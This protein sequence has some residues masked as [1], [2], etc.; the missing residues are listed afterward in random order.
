M[1]TQSFTVI[2]QNKPLP[3]GVSLGAWCPSMDLL[4]LVF[5]DGTL[6]LHRLDW[7]RLW[8]T[9]P[10]VPITALAWRRDGCML[11]TGVCA[12]QSLSL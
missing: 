2:H 7:H 4:A 12:A 6:A 1:A 11:A 9:A 5:E 8:L 3:S 10:D